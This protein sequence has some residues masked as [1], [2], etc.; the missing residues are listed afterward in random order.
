MK[1]YM[2]PRK[3]KLEHFCFG[4]RTL[5]ENVDEETTTDHNFL[6]EEFW[7]GGYL[8]LPESSG[9]TSFI[10]LSL[11]QKESF[12][13]LS[14]LLGFDDVFLLLVEDFI[15]VIRVVGFVLKSS[16]DVGCYFLDV[17]DEGSLVLVVIIPRVGLTRCHS[18]PVHLL[19]L[20][21]VID[22]PEWNVFASK[23]GLL[24]RS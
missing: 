11:I 19:V 10:F 4:K 2:M 18:S 16:L 17:M 1:E 23:V 14:P 20:L 6:A 13:L 22:G 12:R 21:Y 7:I 24:C 5:T 8:R 15:C 3:Q 9:G